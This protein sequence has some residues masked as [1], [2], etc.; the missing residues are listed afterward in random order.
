MSMIGMSTNAVSP[1][2]VSRLL[3]ADDLPPREAQE[4]LDVCP[5]L[6]PEGVD[7]GLGASERRGGP[8]RLPTRSQI[9]PQLI[10]RHW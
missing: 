6:G 7:H 5:A 8:G 9:V 3:F 1:E 10:D 4:V 2:T